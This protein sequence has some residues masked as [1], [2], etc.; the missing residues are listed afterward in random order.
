MGN[1][2]YPD[3]SS[4]DLGLVHDLAHDLSYALNFLC[5]EARVMLTAADKES[6]RDIQTS[7]EAMAGW[8][9]DT[10]CLDE[11]RSLFQE[12]RYSELV[13]L[14]DE[15]QYPELMTESQRRMIDLARKRTGG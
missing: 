5:D 11:I 4:G 13:T 9:C 10:Q 3:C 7:L 14:A 6:S 1:N 8:V 15:I 12:K 2:R